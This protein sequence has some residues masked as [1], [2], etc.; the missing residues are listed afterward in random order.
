MRPEPLQNVSLLFNFGK[1]CFFQKM[2]LVYSKLFSSYKFA[3]VCAV[4][5][6]DKYDN[7]PEYMWMIVVK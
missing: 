1:L 6:V 2:F 3:K 5:R 4:I 7:T